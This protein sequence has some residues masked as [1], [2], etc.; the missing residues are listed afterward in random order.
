MERVLERYLILLK[1]T[2][3]LKMA[4][5][6][7]VATFAE[8]SSSR[9]SDSSIFCALIFV[10]FSCVPN[11]GAQPAPPFGPE[12]G[13]P[14]PPH[15]YPW[16]YNAIFSNICGRARIK[17]QLEQLDMDVVEKAFAK[18]FGDNE[19]SFQMVLTED[20]KIANLQLLRSS[21]S[22]KSDRLAL[23][24]V[25][26]AAPFGRTNFYVNY[27]I[28]VKFPRLKVEPIRNESSEKSEVVHFPSWNEERRFSSNCSLSTDGKFHDRFR[29]YIAE[30]T[31]WLH[32][33]QTSIVEASSDSLSKMGQAANASCTFFVRN[34]GVIDSLK[35]EVSSGSPS[36]DSKLLELVAGA[37]PIKYA[38]P[39]PWILMRPL[40]A[41]LDHGKIRV[42]A[43]R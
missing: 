42:E 37:S 21:G 34:K 43:V 1:L 29:E 26:E 25:K 36:I 33:C 17:Q 24:L 7:H 16:R 20:G 38:P 41:T 13:C 14:S 15:K 28:L 3:L 6:P 12:Y 39:N 23:Q 9:R 22:T 18:K 10:V 5:S 35:I 31:P 30:A 27:P 2:P 8:R 40:R 19:I 4:I 11:A 32:F